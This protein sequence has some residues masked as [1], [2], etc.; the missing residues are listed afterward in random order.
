ML[1]IGTVLSKDSQDLQS[2][3]INRAVFYQ[4]NKNNLVSTKRFHLLK[5]AW[6]RF[7]S[8]T[9]HKASNFISVEKG[10]YYGSER[11]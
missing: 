7:V 8:K 1:Y 6:Q 9:C 5:C 3:E 11:Y 2:L 4:R 10:F